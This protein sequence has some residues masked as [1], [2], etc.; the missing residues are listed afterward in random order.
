MT[1][2]EK[3]VALEP[4]SLLEP[5]TLDGLIHAFPFPEIRQQQRE[6]LK[7]VADAYDT[8][9]QFTIL[10]L[11]V[12]SGKSGI[13]M[14]AGIWTAQT[15]GGG[16]H[17]L[18]SQNMLTK[19][20]MGD[21]GAFDL[22]DIKGK[23]NYDC[24]MKRECKGKDPITVN[25]DLGS[26][27]NDDGL[28]CPGCTYRR[29]KGGYLSGLLGT[30]NYTY[31]LTE[32]MYSKELKPREYL[33]LDEAHN[34]ES[35]ILSLIDI[36]ITQ[37]RCDDLGVGDLP[38]V[39]IHERE[40]VLSWLS[41]VFIPPADLQVKILKSAIDSYRKQGVDVLLNPWERRAQGPFKSKAQREGETALLS[42]YKQLSSLTRLLGNIKLFTE[43]G[44]DSEWV[45]WTNEEGA[46]QI[47]P[48]SAAGFANEYLFKGS[49]NIL[50]MSGTILN[51]TTFQRCL[52]IN[53]RHSK[54]LALP[55]DFPKGNRRILYRPCGNMS[56]KTQA[57]TLPVMA[58]RCSAILNLFPDVKGIIHA[59]SYKISDYLAD[60][61]EHGPH[62]RR[63][64]THAANVPGD[65]ERAIE[66]HYAAT[67]P[68]ILLS[69]SMGEGVDL[70]DDLSR[71]QIITKVPYPKLD[72]YTR[73]RS[74]RDPDWY[75][76]Q[77]AVALQQATGRSNRSASD[78]CITVILDAEF[79]KFMLRN[80]N[81]FSPWWL[82][83]LEFR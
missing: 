10:D 71:I 55:S 7:V 33:I 66:A 5:S 81:M 74:E 26:I 58:E 30:T 45:A 40:K 54:T 64:L 82:D 75:A 31:Y 77:T 38:R 13:G 83:S 73:M 12:G 34:I 6:A 20:L 78:H 27:M 44:R 16:C 68:T 48:L 49:P 37:R 41:K 50:L 9:T 22:R 42:R 36:Q 60:A 1:S 8:N 79:E 11:P 17:Y 63:I 53:P 19:Q 57:A 46:L 51:F 24:H 72:A 2:F 80:Q 76:L 59:H 29:A 65:R 62:A 52:G 43:D 25:C 18:T 23:A 32:T 70:K 67:D 69:P 47:K 56:S 14:A 61:L 39:E 35:E 28:V 3:P 4:E 21:F 15:G